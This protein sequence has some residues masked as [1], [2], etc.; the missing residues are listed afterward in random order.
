[1]PL[2]VSVRRRERASEC[3]DD[4]ERE[5]GGGSESQIEGLKHRRVNLRQLKYSCSGLQVTALRRGQ[6][7]SGRNSPPKSASESAAQHR[8]RRRGPQS[9]ARIQPR[10]LVAHDAEEGRGARGGR[11]GASE[12]VE[13]GVGVATPASAGESVASPTSNRVRCVPVAAVALHLCSSVTSYPRPLGDALTSI[14]ARHRERARA[15]ESGECQETR[16]KISRG[17]G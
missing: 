5:R 7:F 13:G 8:R 6:G 4:G 15:G 9:Y 3:S 17:P 10:D 11:E 1:M 2:C 14:N 16:G 12:P